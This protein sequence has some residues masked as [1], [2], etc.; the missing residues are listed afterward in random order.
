MYQA[1]ERFKKGLKKVIPHSLLGSVINLSHLLEAIFANVRY[2]FPARGMKFIGVTGTNG[3]TTTTLMVATILEGAGHKVGMS[4]SAYI[5]DGGEMRINDLPGL[6]TNPNPI[7]LQKLLRQMK[8]NGVEWVALE[9][10]SH[11]L[12]Q[13]RVWGIKLE[14][15][16]I[17]NITED[18]LDYHGTMENY[19]KAKG[20][21]FGMSR[22]VG[23]V[24]G[25]DPRADYFLSL[26]T[27]HKVT[28]GKTRGSDY[29][30]ADIQ[31]GQKNMAVSLN[32]HG[33]PAKLNL[34]L[35]GEFNA[36]NAAA[37]LAATTEAGIDQTAAITALE[38][39]VRVPGR[40]D[41]VEA[42]QDFSVLVDDAHTPDA[43]ANLLKAARVVTK[44]KVMIITGTAGERPSSRRAPMAKVA[45]TLADVFIMT[46]DEPHG[47]N[48]DN[49]LDEMETG[50][51]K[52]KAQY[53]RITDRCD[54]MREAFAMAKKGDTIILA[55]MGYKNHRDGPNGA[56]PWDDYVAAEE[57]LRGEPCQYEQNW[58][59]V[60]HTAWPDIR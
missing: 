8:N 28:Y 3:K 38:G 58:R 11:A 1:Y 43:I 5:K 60:M 15:A 25:D 30:I 48:P 29:H 49:V 22:N 40:F 41:A 7:V 26:D 24:N 53:L 56:E 31:F 23:V 44:G 16:I 19:T 51:V 10:G 45:S 4:T 6:L 14:A 47:E 2:G 17:T 39:L 52:G 55:G 57:L 37:A 13:H 34:K 46:D 18:H 21:L 12:Q 42:G 54:A 20:L 50:V 32:I 33:K 27:P 35:K 59:A 36:Y 9:C